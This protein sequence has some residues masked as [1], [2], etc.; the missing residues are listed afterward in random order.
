MAHDLDQKPRSSRSSRRQFLALL[1][2]VAGTA[3]L[4]ACG[5]AVSTVATSSSAA[6]T[7]TTAA[8][9]KSVAT[10]T[11]AAKTATTSSSVAKATGAPA[12]KSNVLQVWEPGWGLTS[13]IDKG[14][15][16]SL[17]ALAA[18]EPKVTAEIVMASPYPQKFF[19]AAAAGTPPDLVFA[20]PEQDLA[21]KKIVMWLDSY[22]N[23]TKLT[24]TDFFTPGWTQ[25][26]F[27]GHQ[28]ALPLEVDPNFPLVYNQDLL[29]QAGIS[30]PPT[31]I[32]ELDDANQKLF[33]KKGTA[34]GRLGIFPPWMTYGPPNSLYTYFLMF[35]GGWYDPQNPNKLALTQ[36]G[37]V[38]ALTWMKKYADQFGGYAEIQKFAGSWGK[39]GYVGAMSRGF[40]GMG[41]MVS[42]N[43]TYAVKLAQGGEFANALVLASMPVAEGVKA[44]PAW[45]GGWSMGIPSGVKRPDDSWTV[46]QWMAAS[47]EGTDT[48]A[49]INGFLPGYKQSPYFSRHAKDPAVA[50]YIEVLKGAQHPHTVYRLG[51][52]DVPPDAFSKLLLDTVQGKTDISTALKDFETVVV[53]TLNQ[54]PGAH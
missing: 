41:P 15:T 21:Y 9:T 16:A 46:L 43:Y 54:Y 18:K 20:V 44:D 45:A 42:A 28:Y 25:T 32:A 12:A 48:W 2:S 27:Q 13:P 39:N 10:S 33:Q 1:V 51:W 3:S 36:P 29:Q 5:G 11:T 26:R 6:A 19:A 40:L 37:N 53:G 23:T 7:S 14:Y 24:A 38:A 31:T 52:P 8:T 34:I 22:L 47:P 4:A 35:G 17:K 30:K 50:G 49:E